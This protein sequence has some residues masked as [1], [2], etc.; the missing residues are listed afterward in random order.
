LGRTPFAKLAIEGVERLAGVAD[1]GQRPM[2]VGVEARGV[3]TD[4]AHRWVLE[5]RPRTGREAATSK[6]RWDSRS[7][8]A[9]AATW[10]VSGRG[11]EISW[12]TGSKRRSGKS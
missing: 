7:A 9:A 11:R 6:G 1:D 10:L 5:H 2:F 3:D 4:E 8:A 12:T